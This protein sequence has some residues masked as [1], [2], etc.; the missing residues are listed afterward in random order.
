MNPQNFPPTSAV[1]AILNEKRICFV[2]FRCSD[3]LKAGIERRAVD[4]GITLSE[5]LCILAL[6]DLKDQETTGS[7]SLNNPARDFEAAAQEARRAI[8]DGRITA[9]ERDRIARP[10]ARGLNKIYERHSA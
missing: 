6:R 2:G 9:P 4:L 7:T 5:H 10:A 8:S 1:R 3:V